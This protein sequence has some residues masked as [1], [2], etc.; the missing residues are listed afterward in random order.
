MRQFNKTLLRTMVDNINHK[1]KNKYA[2]EFSYGGVRLVLIH[3]S[4][5]ASEVSYRT[6][7][8]EMGRML[9]CVYTVLAMESE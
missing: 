3:E 6:N 2:L 7:M 4:G 8:Q 1:T 9:D 5:G